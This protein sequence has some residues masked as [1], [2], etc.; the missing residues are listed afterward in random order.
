[1]VFG[2]RCAGKL[3]FIYL[4]SNENTS[5]SGIYKLPLKVIAFETGLDQQYI[6]DTLS[7]FSGDGKIHYQDGVVWVVHMRRYHETKV[8]GSRKEY[9]MTLI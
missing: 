5:L 1:M 2:S 3:L 9:R 4:F 8:R 6:I 7:K